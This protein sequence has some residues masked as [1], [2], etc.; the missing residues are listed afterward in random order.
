MAKPTVT[1][2]YKVEGDDRSF[3]QLAKS[4]DGLKAALKGT[5]E[6]GKKLNSGWINLAALTSALDQA[7]RSLQQLQSALNELTGAYQLQL[8]AETK[9]ETVMRQRMGATDEEVQAIKNLCSAQQELGVIG[10]EVQLAGAQQ[11]ATFLKQ[12]STLA[13]LIP[14]MNNL[15]AQQAGLNA[16][17]SDATSVANL[18]GKAMMGQTSSLRRV[19]ITFDAAQESVLKYGNEQE[20]AA[21]LAE[22]IKQNVGNMNA[23][24]AKTDAGKA[25]QMA[26]TMG[27]LKEKVG[28]AVQG[29]APYINVLA[30][31]TIALSGVVK[32][33][34]GMKALWLWTVRTTAVQRLQIA[35]MGRHGVFTRMAAAVR[36]YTGSMNGAI[37]SA[38]ALTVATRVL[39]TALKTTIVGVVISL[40]IWAFASLSDKVDESA[41]KM[42]KFASAEAI[43][44]ES[45]QGVAD[46]HK[47][48]EESVQ[49]QIAA[50]NIDIAKLKDFTGT[51]AEEKKMV[52]EL[53]TRYG[54]RLGYCKKVSDWY[55]LLTSNSKDYCRQLEIE[56]ETQELAKQAAKY[57][58]AAHNIAYD[59]KGNKRLYSDRLILPEIGK[60]YFDI[61]KGQLFGGESVEDYKK[62]QSLVGSSELNEAQKS[63]DANIKARNAARRRME[64]LQKQSASIT[65]KKGLS[66]DPF[67]MSSPTG[68]GQ[69]TSAAAKNEPVYTPGATKLKDIEGNIQYYRKQLDEATVD[70][71]AKINKEIA[72]WQKLADTINNAGK[73]VTNTT[74]KSP[75][76]NLQ[77]N[78][79]PE[80]EEN[81]KFYQ[82]KIDAATSDEEADIWREQYDAYE[83]KV[84]RRRNG[85][86]AKSKDNKAVFDAGAT[87][88]KGI[89][90]NIQA[91]DDQLQTAGIAEA[92]MINRQIAAWQKKADAIRKAGT[93]SRSAMDIFRKT[94]G[95]VSGGVSAVQSLTDAIDNNADAWTVIS[96][97][98]DTFLQLFSSISSIIDIIKSIT[99]ATGA[100][101]AV[102]TAQTAAKK[103]ETAATVE[104]TVS[105]A[106]ETAAASGSAI[107]KATAAGAGL[108][109][110]ANLGAIAA[111][112][113]AVLAALGIIGTLAFANGGIVPGN[114][115]IGDHLI[116]RVNSGEMILNAGQQRNLFN[117]LNGKA[118]ASGLHSIAA[119]PVFPKIVG[120]VRGSDIILSVANTS[121]NGSHIGRRSGIII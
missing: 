33:A 114:S 5:F 67:A 41:E 4:A 68:S 6:E 9:L 61:W 46:A 30:S 105:L 22:V 1:I 97:G 98:V 79:L 87:T 50:L 106:G 51:Q 77:A 13:E 91:L 81:L 71:A 117:L 93:E 72:Y 7:Q 65:L 36:I 73:A 120:K 37:H 113:G 11:L 3:R 18:M 2:I 49:S 39:S 101:V 23:E 76:L 24:L 12:K 115:P 89:E 102:T 90:D 83:K 8:E 58:Q 95:T 29:I 32:L 86:E 64:E 74:P 82:G 31:A 38:R 26:N 52:Q 69:G 104:N 27:D 59:E 14:A 56:A 112:V 28:G 75:T 116:A 118:S 35:L 43:A 48:A 100:V 70:T 99:T 108:P 42:R 92:A 17:Q 57:D 55:E 94:W 119:T 54:E 107:A 53:N 109:F 16:S 111:G 44:A 15:V 103:A 121:H 84:N 10:D 34:A 96:T 45:A 66:T 88:L 85:P 25:K 19:G 20:R 78:T 60:S 21:M 63:Y 80:M 62:R 40:A 110:P 47:A